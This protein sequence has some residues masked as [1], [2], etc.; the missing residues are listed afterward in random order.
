MGRNYRIDWI[1]TITLICIGLFGLFLLATINQTLFLQQLAFLIVGIALLIV[2]SVVH[3]AILWWLAPFG[4]IG[5]LFFLTITYVAP[6]V[7]GSHRWLSIGGLA[8]QPSEF[9][10]PILLLFFTWA[11][12]R[13]PPRQ[14]K[15]IPLH[16]VLFLVP[17]LLVLKQPDLG[18]A[19]VYGSF[20]LAMMLAG[21]FSL[22]LVLACGTIFALSIPGLWNLLAPYQR[23]RIT[24]FLSPGHDPAGA[25]YNAIQAMIAVGSGQ[26]FGRGLG[27]GTQ[28]HLRFL[29]EHH[30]D[31]I[32]ATLVEELGFVGGALLIAGYAYLLWRVIRP[33]VRGS[34]TDAYPYIFTI[35]LF[36]MILTQI[37][38]NTGMNMGIIPI[39]G[40]TLPFV[41]YGG[42]SVLS[43][44][45]SFGL[46]WAIR[47][48]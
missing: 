21:G 30:T 48:R 31:F 7:R 22:P 8:L 46:L 42:S 41:S 3:P 13:F 45:L 6:A 9:V 23:D 17:F 25:G 11:I 24:T 20:W 1:S 36:S 19:V 40:I 18:T 34:L 47:G 28:S 26:L 29:P 14:A 44:C 12:T 16:I 10:K 43:L 32:F 27:R 5:S 4:F 38:I 39:T 15:Y 37:F 2:V 35:G 33:L